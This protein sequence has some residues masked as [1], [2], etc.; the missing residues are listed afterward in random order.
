MV[1][2]ALTIELF[3]K[4]LACIETGAVPW[5]HNLKELCSARVNALHLRFVT[6]SSD[7]WRTNCLSLCFP[8]G[9][10]ICNFMKGLIKVE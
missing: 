8:V 7:P 1:I 5:G 6:F 9:W 2:G 4:C 10:Q 3:F